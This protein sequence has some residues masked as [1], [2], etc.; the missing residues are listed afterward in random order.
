[1]PK[2]KKDKE[3]KKRKQYSSQYLAEIAGAMN[4][5]EVGIA[6]ESIDHLQEIRHIR[7]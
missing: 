5:V 6:T 1:M 4:A 7:E 3:K 2:S